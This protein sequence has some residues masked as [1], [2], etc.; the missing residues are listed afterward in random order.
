MKRILVCIDDDEQMLDF[1]RVVLARYGE[2]RVAP[3]L[4]HARPLLGHCDLILLDFYLER[5][6]GLFQH[7][8]PELRQ[9]A[10]VL[11]CSGVDD[12][13]V[14]A[15]GQVLGVA[16]YWHKSSDVEALYAQVDAAL[17]AAG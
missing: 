1:Y 5:D 11:L 2:V 9:S 4:E 13:R 16:G 17:A 8:V 15:M 12:V 6:T 3:D 10:P 14:P 7:I